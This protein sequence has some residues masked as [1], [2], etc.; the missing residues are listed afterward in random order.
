MSVRSLSL[1]A[2]ALSVGYCDGEFVFELL[3]CS[4]GRQTDL[5]E[6]CVRDWQPAGTGGGEREREKE[7]GAVVTLKSF[8][9]LRHK[10]A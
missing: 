5:I 1:K 3:P 7:K 10:F 4:I 2:E 8:F 9:A 6:T